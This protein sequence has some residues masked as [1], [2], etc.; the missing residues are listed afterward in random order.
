MLSVVLPNSLAACGF[1][2]MMVTSLVPSLAWSDIVRT[3]SHHGWFVSYLSSC[4]GLDRSQL[5]GFDQVCRGY[6]CYDLIFSTWR[7]R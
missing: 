1:I 6:W 2:I 7:D 3:I 5:C 4:D